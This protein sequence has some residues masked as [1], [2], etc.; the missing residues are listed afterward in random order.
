MSG[1]QS[2]PKCLIDVARHRLCVGGG[3]SSVAAAGAEAFVGTHSVDTGRRFLT[4]VSQ[5]VS[6]G[7]DTLIRVQNRKGNMKALLDNPPPV[8]IHIH[9]HISS[10]F[11]RSVGSYRR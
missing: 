6:N 2:V 5:G 7:K 4:L 3:G 1:L 11:V 10:V 8:F 9:I